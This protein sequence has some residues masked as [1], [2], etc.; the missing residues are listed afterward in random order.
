MSACLSV[1]LS[2]CL[3]MFM[4]VSVS[5]SWSLSLS[6]SVHVSVSVSVSATVCLSVCLSVFL[7]FYM[8]LS[9]LAP[10]L[11]V[12]LSVCLSLCFFFYNFTKITGCSNLTHKTPH[13]SWHQNSR[14]IILAED[15]T[16]DNNYS[17]DNQSDFRNKKGTNWVSRRQSNDSTQERRLERRYKVFS[18]SRR[19]LNGS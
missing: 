17:N 7:S 2:V 11:F 4:S 15:K 13:Y 3:F 5:R 6:V 8:S 16:N 1:C 14:K 9:S 18:C 19:Y 10:C 12:C